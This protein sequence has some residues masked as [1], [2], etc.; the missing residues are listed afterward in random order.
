MSQMLKLLKIALL[1][2]AKILVVKSI[3]TH[4]KQHSTTICTHSV[5]TW[6]APK[7]VIK[8]LPNN[9]IALTLFVVDVIIFW[10]RI[11]TMLQLTIVT[12]R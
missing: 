2:H 5:Y 6:D 10:I 4:Y 11:C 8:D 12:V 9:K 1:K 3:L 7:F